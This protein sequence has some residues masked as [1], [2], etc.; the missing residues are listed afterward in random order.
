M[1]TVT[2][3]VGCTTVRRCAGDRVPPGFPA[4]TRRG[5]GMEA[6]PTRP[7]YRRHWS[8][9]PRTRYQLG[10]CDALVTAIRSTPMPPEAHR[11]RLSGAIRG[12]AMATTAIG[13]NLLS[14]EEVADALESDYP[15]PGEH[16]FATEVRNA[17]DALLM[18]VDEA[19]GDAPA[20]VDSTLLLRVHGR[21]GT[22]LGEHLGATP[23]QL[24]TG[25]ARATYSAPRADDVPGLLDGLF[26]WLDREFP[27]AAPGGDFGDAVV[28]A[29]AT[30]VYLLWI[31]PFSDGNGRAARALESYVLMR[32]G[33]PA[34][35][36]Q[37]LTCFYHETRS[38]YLR[39]LRLAT[40]DRSLT[41]FIAYAAE[42]LRDG[43]VETLEEVRRIQLESAWREFVYDRF[44]AHP[45]RKRTVLRR[46]RD[47]ML[48]FPLGGRL[49]LGQAGLLNPT[50]AQRYGALSERTLRRDLA[51]L[52]RI[53]LLVE[54]DGRFLANTGALRI[55]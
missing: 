40:A 44:D 26:G 45:Q 5:S 34:I 41:S 7:R 27:R 43:L 13:G 3:S 11:Q 24:R 35:A 30:H 38:E 15:I 20:P 17:A 8:I 25:E 42:G 16:H 10:E 9:S 52:A 51:F 32:S 50:I 4:R 22:G 23:G 53:G 1:E 36:S 12:A 29:A 18:L 19:A 46:R 6:K 55:L 48:A 33:T 37:I 31:R 14:A 49:E 2:E 28:R 39:Q 54:A 47:L 21:I